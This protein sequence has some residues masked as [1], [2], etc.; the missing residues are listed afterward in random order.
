MSALKRMSTTLFQTFLENRSCAEW[1]E[2]GWFLAR[3]RPLGT[4]H[5]LEA[6]ATLIFR[7]VER[8]AEMLPEGSSAR[9]HRYH[10][11]VFV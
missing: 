10:A 7:S 11:T 6:Y 8:F 4:Q 9:A 3:K 2:W 5:R 1:R